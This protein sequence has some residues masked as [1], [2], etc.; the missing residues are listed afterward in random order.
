MIS[1]DVDG[2]V[3][4]D[5]YCCPVLRLWIVLSLTA[6]QIAVL[7]VPKLSPWPHL[8][9]LV[10]TERRFQSTQP[11]TTADPAHPRRTAASPDQSLVGTCGSLSVV[12][13]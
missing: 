11:A 12:T 4:V 2:I 10:D 5:A 9:Q 8:K 6:L 7:F 1:D 3:E 13:S